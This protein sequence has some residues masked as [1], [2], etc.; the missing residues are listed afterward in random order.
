MTIKALTNAPGMCL[1]VV[2]PYDA[3][4]SLQAVDASAIFLVILLAIG[5]FSDISI[6]NLEVGF[7]GIVTET[8]GIPKEA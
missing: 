7:I 5:P 6:L 8:L 1:E 2:R 4:T 3:K